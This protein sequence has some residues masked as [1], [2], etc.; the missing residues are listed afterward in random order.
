MRT[1]TYAPGN[2][3]VTVAA[4]EDGTPKIYTDR[5]EAF[6]VAEAWNAEVLAADGY[7][8]QFEGELAA[9]ARDLGQAIRKDI[10]VEHYD[11]GKTA[12]VYLTRPGVSTDLMAEG[13]IEWLTAW[14]HGGLHAA[15]YAM[16]HWD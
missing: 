14:F 5:D 13:Q 9:Q 15:R 1:T 3:R 16:G 12:G 11:D 4:N 6:K 8:I 2:G 10:H 7:Y